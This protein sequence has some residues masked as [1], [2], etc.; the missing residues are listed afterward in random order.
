MKIYEFNI[1]ISSYLYGTCLVVAESE[2]FARE[3]LKE[4]TLNNTSLKPSDW[5]YT[6]ELTDLLPGS[7]EGV[8]FYKIY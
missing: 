2:E 4:F 1:S 5:E 3:Y 7:K 6:K 8:V